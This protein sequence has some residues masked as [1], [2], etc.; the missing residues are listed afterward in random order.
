VGAILFFSA[1][2]RNRQLSRAPKDYFCQIM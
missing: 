1:W 2:I